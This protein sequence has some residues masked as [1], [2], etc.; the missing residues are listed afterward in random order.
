MIYPLRP[1]NCMHPTAHTADFIYGI[2][3]GRRVTYP[4]NLFVYFGR[5]ILKI[6]P[7][8]GGY[9]GSGG[10]SKLSKRKRPTVHDTLH[11]IEDTERDCA[12]AE[13]NQRVDS[14]GRLPG[15]SFFYREPEHHQ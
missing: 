5:A 15:D 6:K 4:G 3:A 14:Q 2:G 13:Q 10:K 7:G 8:K 9:T 1:D 11:I 12:H